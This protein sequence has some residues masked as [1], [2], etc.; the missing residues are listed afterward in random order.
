MGYVAARRTY[1]PLNPIMLGNEVRW[2]GL[3]ATSTAPAL[4]DLYPKEM[5]NR[6]LDTAGVNTSV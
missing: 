4:H 3:K 2:M 6:S 1:D 5:E